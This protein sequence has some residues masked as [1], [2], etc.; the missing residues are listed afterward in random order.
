VI[1]G[2]LGAEVLVPR[3]YPLVGALLRLFHG[4]VVFVRRQRLADPAV[5]KRLMRRFPENSDMQAHG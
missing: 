2:F 4:L 5:Q 1:L 3:R